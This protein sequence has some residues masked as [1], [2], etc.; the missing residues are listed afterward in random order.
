MPELTGGKLRGLIRLADDNGRFKM[1]AIDQRGSLKRLLGKLLDREPTYEEMAQVKE[2]IT[3]H[4][5]PY[6][7]AVLTDPQYGYPFSTRHLSHATGLLLA[8]EETGAAKVG[9]FEDRVSG[10]IEGWGIE[11][12]LRAGA[13]AIKLLVYFHPD[14]I[15]Q[16]REKQCSFVRE[17]GELCAQ[18]SRP[19]LLELV[20]YAR[21]EVPEPRRS[22]LNEAGRK[23]EDTPEFARA[24]PDIV[25]RSAEEFSK[26]K[27]QVD[28]L[29]LEFPADLKYTEEYCHRVFDDR[30]REPVY[31]LEEVQ[32][33]CQQ[34]DEAAGVPWVILSAGVEIEEFLVQVELATEAGA[35]GFLCGRAIWKE[36][37]QVKEGNGRKV[38]DV[39]AMEAW[40][41]TQGAYNFARANAAAERAVPWFTRRPYAGR[42]TVVVAGRGENWHREF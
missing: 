21:D 33:Y 23:L 22:E 35:S 9:P 12:A 4:L 38:L 5:A 39:E 36:A 17:V 16:A 24:K 32:D 20:S 3:K 26:P 8:Y 40:L 34:L 7:T 10:P 18:H 27:Y 14:A 30:E 42:D 29:K 1:M 6:A 25:V 31:T 11:K 2:L 28:I 37:P 41:T 15:P 13:D 19:F